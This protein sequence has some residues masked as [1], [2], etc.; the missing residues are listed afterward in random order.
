[1]ASVN[2]T[3]LS[4]A[5]D[6]FSD[7]KNPDGSEATERAAEH[8]VYACFFLSILLSITPG[9][10]AWLTHSS[11]LQMITS[12]NSAKRKA[13]QNDITKDN[14]ERAIAQLKSFGDSRFWIANFLCPAVVALYVG[15]IV[16]VWSNH[17]N[18]VA[19]VTTIGLA[20]CI[21][22]VTRVIRALAHAQYE[23][24]SSQA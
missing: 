5:H 18:G 3:L 6:K 24:Q 10:F 9:A 21:V 15:V 7:R 19:L 8:T 1:M 14:L 12:A 4:Y 22:Q 17:S 11:T 20:Y 13:P 16:L 2:A 23:A